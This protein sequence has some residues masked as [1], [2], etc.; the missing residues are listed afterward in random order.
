MFSEDLTF[1]AGEMMVCQDIELLLDNDLENTE[2]FTVNLSANDPPD[3]MIPFPTAT[4]EILDADSKWLFLC[5]GSLQLC[6]LSLTKQN[7]LLV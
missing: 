7:L 1:V 4:V 3:V 6:C 2:S 5:T